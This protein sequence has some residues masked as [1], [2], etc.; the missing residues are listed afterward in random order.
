MKPVCH[1][2]SR[3]GID[4]AFAFALAF[5]SALALAET[6]KLTLTNVRT[7]YGLLGPAR[8]DARALPGD[9]LYLDFDI[10]G[11][12]VAADGKVQYSMSLETLDA[13]G[14]VIYRQNALDQEGLASL[15]GQ[16]VPAQAHLDI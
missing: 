10:A 1:R 11:I 2:L 6:G 16:S 5:S 7:T 3:A 9:T 14:K 8:A 12:T 4:V 13:R 15:G